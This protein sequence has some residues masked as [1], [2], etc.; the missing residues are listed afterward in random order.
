MTAEPEVADA[1]PSGSTRT[2]TLRLNGETRTVEI[3]QAATLLQVLRDQLGITSARSACGIGVCG[4]CTV[5]VDGKVTSSCI[6]LAAQAH[7]RE[8]TTGEGLRLPSGELSAVQRAFVDRGAY[9]C[10]FCIPAMVLTVHAALQDPEAGRDVESVREY[11][12]GNLCRCGTYPTIL[13]AV[14]DLVG[15]EPADGGAA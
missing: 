4:A 12:A 14:A 6:M 3:D 10:S 15:A 7:D 1:V 11:L 9:Q 2:V 5:L 8:I 13:E